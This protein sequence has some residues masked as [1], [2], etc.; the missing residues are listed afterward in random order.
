VSSVNHDRIAVN[1]LHL[2]FR[3][4]DTLDVQMSARENDSDAVEHPHYILRVN[5][6]G[7]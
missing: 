3:G 5:R 6:Y 7:I 2:R 1:I 4:S